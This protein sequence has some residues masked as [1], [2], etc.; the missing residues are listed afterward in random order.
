M[1]YVI[2]DI[3]GCYEKYRAILQTIRLRDRDTLYVLG[4]VIDRGPDGIRVLRDMMGRANVYPILGNHEFMAAVC[5]QF[6][7]QEIRDDTIAQLNGTET[8]ALAD[9]FAN[10]GEVTL[11]AFTALPMEA[12]EDILDYLGEFTLYENVQAGGQ[13]YVLIH[14]G[15]ANFVPGKPLDDYDPADFLEG[16]PDYS[17]APWPDRILV[18]GHTPTRLIPGNSN[19]DR[20]YRGNRHIAID[21]GCCFGGHLAALCLDTGE[22]FYV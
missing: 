15:L 13:Q 22:E 5:L 11:K 16:R 14:A 10:G 2:G 21:C 12:R 8:A 1:H 19:P 17:V 6:L 7:M 4:D 3:H 20:I 18:S 9:W